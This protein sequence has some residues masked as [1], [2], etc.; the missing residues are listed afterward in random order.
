MSADDEL[1]SLAV[2]RNVTLGMFCPKGDEDCTFPDV[3]V[4]IYTEKNSVDSDLLVDS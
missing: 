2:P 4:M 3:Y 1:L